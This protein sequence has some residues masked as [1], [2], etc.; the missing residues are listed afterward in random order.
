MRNSWRRRK[1]ERFR[2]YDLA[3]RRVKGEMKRKSTL[4][5]ANLVRLVN[6][7]REKWDALPRPNG[8]ALIF[9]AKGNFVS[10]QGIASVMGIT[11][12]E[13]GRLRTLARLQRD[14]TGELAMRELEEE[15]VADNPW[16]RIPK[17]IKQEA[18]FERNGP[19]FGQV[20]RDAAPFRTKDGGQ[21]VVMRE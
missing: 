15:V 12:G 14:L 21:V 1:G 18:F 8:M 17:S 7:M 16:L 9:A 5:T 2:R 4:T 19:W 11:V 3:T 10:P 13:L 20:E 6:E